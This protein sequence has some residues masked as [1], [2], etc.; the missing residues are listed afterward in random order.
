MRMNKKTLA[1]ILTGL[2]SN[3]A[4]AALVDKS[5]LIVDQIQIGKMD[6]D[7]EPS[8]YSVMFNF[9]NAGDD[10]NKWQIGFYMPR[11]FYSLAA[12]NI[13]PALEMQVCNADGG[14][15]NLHYVKSAFNAPDLSQG[16]FTVLEP[17][18]S[19]PL[20]EKGRYYIRLA[21]SNQWPAGNVSALPQ[22]LFLISDNYTKKGVPRIYT[23]NTELTQYSLLGYD[24][25]QVETQI[26]D[27]L[28]ANWQNSQN[29]MTDSLPGIVPQPVSIKAFGNDGFTPPKQLT[30]HNQLNDNNSVVSLWA[31]IIKSDWKQKKP[32]LFDND[33]G[34]N[35]G[36]I[37]TEIS[38][39]KSIAN[40]PEGYR[41]TINADNITIETL[42]QTGAY[43]ALQTL[44]QIWAQNKQTL[45][46]VTV[47]DYPRFKYRGVLL[48]TARHY[49][50][51]AEIKTLLDVMASQKLN[52]LHIHFADDEAF[53]LGLEAYPNLTATAANRGLGQAI[54]PNML[55][56]NNL[57]TTN[58]TQQN[59]PLANSAY[60]GSYS[61]EEIKTLISYANANQITIIPEI[62][63]PGHARALIKALPEVMV[64][65]NDNSQFVSVQGYSDDVLPVC[66]Y[67]TDISVGNQFTPTMNTIM[68]NVAAQFNNQS[69]VYAVNNE[70]SVG[71][72]EV[73][74]HA[75]TNDTS[76]R[77]EWSDLSA[78]EKSHLFFQK[79]ANSNSELVF[80]GWQ[81]FIQNDNETLGKNIVAANQTGHVW[82]W[83]PSAEGV[84]Q[85]A[86]L[87]NNNYPTVLAYADKTYFDLAYTPSMYE[88]GFTWAT[89]YSD[90]Y[91]NLSMAET[92]SKT[93]S[94]AKNPQNI[95]GIEGTLWSENLPSFDHLM[96]MALPKMPGLAEAGWSPNWVTINNKQLDWQ[97]LATRLGCG[98]T[99]FLAYLHQSFS[100]NYR[101][102]PHGISRELPDGNSLCTTTLGANN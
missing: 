66:T 31:Q 49:F 37:I 40:S 89:G 19:F 91:S 95:V 58:L 52:T 30:I 32:V 50:S 20:K 10:I 90:T 24:H 16:Y 45:P 23:I 75:W 57:D 9:H 83:N 73:S 74:S 5:D 12:Q 94:K 78:L 44:R 22:N 100:V 53:R 56:Q 93:Q 79:L 92:A 29:F 1:L 102:Y 96:Y 42:T 51:V 25:N 54:G 8:Q 61:A 41:L 15:A 39:P 101:G 97:S 11:S 28:T 99:G 64:D 80:S 87:A 4:F 71:G 69:T 27:K 63:L 68:K 21:H 46:S 2:V 36:I 43:Y 81:Q 38:D 3:N 86:S 60:N 65:P 34:A 33:S 62:D 88:P 72:D 14:C 6:G 48:D 70:V 98:E 67:G 17:I 18:S 82:V 13:N 84:K 59:Y 76:C 26:K 35:T 7:T 55:P 47:T 85:A 77:N